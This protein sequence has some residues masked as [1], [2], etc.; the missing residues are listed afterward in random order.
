MH[1]TSTINDSVFAFTTSTE[2][3]IHNSLDHFY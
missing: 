1:V 2:Y 3:D